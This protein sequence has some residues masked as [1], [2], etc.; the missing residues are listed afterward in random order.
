MNNEIKV[1]DK[2]MAG[3]AELVQNIGN[4]IVYYEGQIVK[5]NK[6]NCIV[7]INNKEYK[8]NKNNIYNIKEFNEIKGG[9]R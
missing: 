5:I 3:K 9:V 4:A 1:N 2:V 6:V 8:V 7:S